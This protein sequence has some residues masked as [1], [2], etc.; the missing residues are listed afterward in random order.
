MA[1]LYFRYGAMRSAKTL[2][3]LAVAH[4]YGEQNKKVLLVKPKVDDRYGIEK[5][6]SRAGLKADADIVI[7]GDTEL[8]QNDFNG[9]SCVL[10]DEAHFLSAQSI[11][12]HCP[13]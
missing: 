11:D 9:L 1:K 7:D 3:C 4:N 2:N 6:Q 12:Q 5:I 10:V 13:R 8:D